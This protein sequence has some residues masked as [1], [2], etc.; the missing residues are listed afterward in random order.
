MKTALLFVNGEVTANEISKIKSTQ[1]ILVIAADGGASHALRFGYQPQHVVGDLDSIT[2]EIKKQ[3]SKT[4]FLQDPSQHLNDLE[5]ALKFCEIEEVKHLTVLGISGKRLD[6]TLNNLSVI[7]RFDQ[8]FK[9]RILD[10]HSEIFLV[11]QSWQYS[12]K[13]KQLI[14]LI[15]LGTVEGITTEGLAFALKDESLDFGKR[16]GLS[17]YIVSSPVSVKIT[18]GLLFIFVIDP[19]FGAPVSKH[20]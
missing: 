10:A 7:S 8:K 2:P 5:K 12:G 14:S 20:D 18:R 17:N 16:E 6:H 9:L 19:E 3:L 1:F 13:E 11:R 4:Q 15:P